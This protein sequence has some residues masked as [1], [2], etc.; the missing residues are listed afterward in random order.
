[1]R[2][3]V[4]IKPEC[5]ETKLQSTKLNIV[6]KLS[7]NCVAVVVVGVVVVFLQ[8]TDGTVADYRV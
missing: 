8:R 6:G 2:N 3:I 5:P 4:R 1:M 7:K